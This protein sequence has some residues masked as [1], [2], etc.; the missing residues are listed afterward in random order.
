ML[1]HACCCFWLLCQ[2]LKPASNR[3]LEKW[4]EVTARIGLTCHHAPGPAIPTQVLNSIQS[5]DDKTQHLLFPYGG[6]FAGWWLSHD[7]KQEQP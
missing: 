5:A 7:H 2:F 6:F 3:D 1:R 4:V